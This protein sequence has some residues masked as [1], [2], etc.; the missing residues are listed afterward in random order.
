MS[1]LYP[2]FHSSI[3]HW[4]HSVSN[5]QPS[6]IMDIN[7]LRPSQPNR[8]SFSEDFHMNSIALIMLPKTKR[9]PT[10]EDSSSKYIIFK[11]LLLSIWICVV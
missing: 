2:C 7:G 11:Y 10:D 3:L 9:N 5:S 8:Q 6:C 4:A 1:I